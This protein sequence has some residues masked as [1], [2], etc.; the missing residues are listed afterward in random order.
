MWKPRRLTTQWASTACYNDSF[1]WQ[2]VIQ[3]WQMNRCMRR[4][5]AVT[6]ETEVRL[7]ILCEI[8]TWVTIKSTDSWVATRCSLEPGRRFGITN[9]LHGWKVSQ[10]R[11]SQNQATACSLILFVYSLAYS[12]DIKVDICSFETSGSVRTVGAPF[13]YPLLFGWPPL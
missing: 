9:R 3:A 6:I 7:N 8:L 1:T 10:T 4:D 12:S 2:S 13:S 11:N 5:R